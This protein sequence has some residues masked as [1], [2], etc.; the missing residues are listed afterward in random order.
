[1]GNVSLCYRPASFVGERA[2]NSTNSTTSNWKGTGIAAHALGAASEKCAINQVLDRQRRLSVV[3]DDLTKEDRARRR[4]LQSTSACV[5]AAAKLAMETVDRG[6]VTT[7]KVTT[8]TQ[9]D[10]PTLIPVIGGI[11]GWIFVVGAS[12]GLGFVFPKFDPKGRILK[13]VTIPLGLVII[14]FFIQFMLATFQMGNVASLSGEPVVLAC[15]EGKQLVSGA[16]AKHMRWPQVQQLGC[17]KTCTGNAVRRIG[18]GWGGGGLGL[19]FSVLVAVFTIVG[20]GC[21]EIGAMAFFCS[22]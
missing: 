7:M 3:E 6:D 13:I 2:A 12:Y 10:A 11:G 20:M 17:S 1:M 8:V 5:N 14:V 4:H 15:L 22:L 18:G 21:R 9:S 16:C 19:A